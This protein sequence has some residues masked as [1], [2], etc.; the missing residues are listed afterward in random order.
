MTAP[1]QFEFWVC[2]S[3]SACPNSGNVTEKRSNWA[4]L[5][6][7]HAQF[8]EICMSNSV[9]NAP[10]QVHVAAKVLPPK[11]PDAHPTTFWPSSAPS[12]QVFGLAPVEPPPENDHDE[13]PRAVPR[14][15]RALYHA[16]IAGQTRRLAAAVVGPTCGRRAPAWEG[17]EG[18]ANVPIF[19]H[20][21]AREPSQGVRP[22]LGDHHFR[23]LTTVVHKE[24][25][26]PHVAVAPPRP[27]QA[28]SSPRRRR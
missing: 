23:R 9:V 3:P 1:G 12:A 28:E 15:G 26:D 14:I 22:G 18:S 17:P 16:G 20:R 6:V 2:S 27:A 4:G 10:N 19:Q 5:P 8:G 24:H 25:V 7:V 21:C 13:P 11:E